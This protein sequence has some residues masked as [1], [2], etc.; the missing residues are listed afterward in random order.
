MGITG[1]AGLKSSKRDARHL[2]NRRRD[3]RRKSRYTG[4]SR[5]VNRTRGK[6]GEMH[7]NP[8]QQ[9]RWTYAEK[10]Q[11]ARSLKGSRLTL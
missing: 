5:L 1:S 3:A 4:L 10:E 11:M 7:A 6:E 9:C 2:Q 8:L